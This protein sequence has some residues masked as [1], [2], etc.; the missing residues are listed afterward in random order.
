[1]FYRLALWIVTGP[2]IL[3]NALCYCSSFHSS[4]PTPL[5]FSSSFLFPPAPPS[6]QDVNSGAPLVLLL[7]VAAS[8]FFDGSWRRFSGWRS[9]SRPTCQYFVFVRRRWVFLVTHC[10]LVVYWC[11]SGACSG[12]KKNSSVPFREKPRTQALARACPPAHRLCWRHL[13]DWRRLLWWSGSGI[14]LTFPNCLGHVI[15]LQLSSVSCFYPF[16]L[17]S[18][19][20]GGAAAGPGHAFPTPLHP[21]PAILSGL[22]AALLRPLRHLLLPLLQ[23]H[24]LLPQGGPRLPA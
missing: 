23:R 15:D 13:P 12:F 14:L 17:L 8:I 19:R 7:W 24:L 10:T 3:L 20:D 1:M 18:G 4:S 16:I 21:T 11:L 9:R 2:V 5:Y 22:P 6:Q